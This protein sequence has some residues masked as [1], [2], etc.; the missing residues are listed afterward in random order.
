MTANTV[1][2]SGRTALVTGAGRGLGWGIAVALARA[3]AR[4]CISDINEEDVAR[5]VLSVEDEGGIARGVRL[6]VAD[7]DE[8]KSVVSSVVAEWGRIDTIVH[9]AIY[10]PLRRF[11]DVTDEDWERQISVGLG[12]YYNAVRAAWKP[13]V[14]QGGGHLIGIASGSSLRGYVDE[15]AYCTLKHGLE[16]MVKA[17]SLEVRELGLAVNTMGP[18]ASVKP[19]RLTWQEL[20]ETPDEVKANWEDPRDLGRAFAWLASQD[21][22]A[23]T[24]LRFDAGPI[25]DSLDREGPQFEVVAEK[26]TSYPEDFRARQAWSASQLE[27]GA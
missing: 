5:A 7:G 3:G 14:Q 10:M 1:D 6:D 26:V 2:L 15:V 21:P 18:G 17:L 8:F 22:R 24:G 16:G 12:G 13:M 11:V 19:T 25:R 9:A 20:E 23:W 27:N 4:V